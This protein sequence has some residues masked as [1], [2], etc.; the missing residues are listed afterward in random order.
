M[1][2]ERTIG[3]TIRLAREERGLSQEEVSAE[4]RL[5]LAV[6]RKLELDRFGELPGGLY[7]Q[8]Y[9][10]IL[11]DFLD[12][13]GS[14]LFDRVR[15]V[16]AV[17]KARKLRQEVVIVL[18]ALVF[19]WTNENLRRKRLED[20]SPSFR[21]AQERRGARPQQMP[22]ILFTPM[23][24]WTGTDRKNAPQSPVAAL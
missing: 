13:D 24:R 20:E 10:R 22:E 8:N 21:S 1:I 6:I 16:L 4:T 12:L 14:E 3:E 2:P 19:I 23:L 11:A 15:I 5:S 7:T 9:L 18:D 17:P